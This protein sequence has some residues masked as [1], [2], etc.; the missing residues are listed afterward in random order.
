M[1]KITT[2]A[3]KNKGDIDDKKLEKTRVCAYWRVSTDSLKQAESFEMQTIF[4]EDYIKK[5][6]EWEFA[7]IY[8][9]Q[10]TT[11]TKTDKRLQFKKMIKDCELGKIDLIITK[12]ISRFARNTADCL[13]AV[14][15]LRSLNV[16][17]YF[18][19]EN[20]NTYGADSELILSFLSSIAQDEARSMSENV[21]WS[22]Q[23]KFKEGKIQ[24][25]TKRFLGYDL[26]EDGKLVVNPEEAKIVK[27]I[28]SEYLEGKSLN[29]IK[30][31]LEKDKIKTATGAYTWY[32]SAK[33]V[34]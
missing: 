14:R 16:G 12:S 3:V 34:S 24:I 7:G 26:L 27:R 32:G 29:D 4:Y 19:R 17:V 10:G 13:E 28:F 11:G 22:F 9:D 21:R 2:I 23:K 1:K 25:N 18:E 8:A 30:Y 33:K 15:Y 31:G 5:K 20:I 6:I